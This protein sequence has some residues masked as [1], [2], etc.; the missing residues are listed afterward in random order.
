MPRRFRLRSRR[1]IFLGSL[2][3]LLIAG[4]FAYFRHRNRDQS[5]AVQTD[6]VH[7]GEVVELVA[8]TGR[9]QP[10][11]EVKISA[12]VSGRIDLLR[13]KE[14]DRIQAGQVLVEIDPTRYAAQVS[15]RRRPRSAP[16][17]PSRGSPPPTSSRPSAS[18]IA[19]AR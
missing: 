19:S 18:S 3:L 14:G 2:A 4:G 10:Q 17:V 8:A 11:T 5:T 9:V 12:N 13:V 16:P 15:R 7:R 1:T 6:E